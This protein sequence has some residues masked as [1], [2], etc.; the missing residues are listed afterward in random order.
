MSL[1]GM[2]VMADNTLDKQKRNT[3]G[4]DNYVDQKRREVGSWRTSVTFTKQT[5]VKPHTNLHLVVT[6]PLKFVKMFKCN[7]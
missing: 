4:D 7:V 2:G 6:F 5:A 1:P 3:G